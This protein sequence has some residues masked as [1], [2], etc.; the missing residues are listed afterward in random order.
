VRWGVLGTGSI[1]A[2]FVVDLL[3][4]G[5]PGNQVVAVGSRSA[6][7]AARFGQRFGIAREHVGADSLVGDE[8][9]DVVYV[10]TPNPFHFAHALGA[11]RAGK[12]VLVEK[13]FVL[14]AA[15]ARRLVEE[16]RDNGVLLVEAMWTRF[17]PTMQLVRQVIDGGEIG[18]VRTLAAQLGQHAPYE[19]ESRLWSRRLG[20]GALLDMGPYLLALASMVLGPA[21]S[22][23][24]TSSRAPTGVD[25][26]TSIVLRH[27]GGRHSLLHTSLVGHDDNR[28]VI[29]GSAGRLEIPAPFHQQQPVDIVTAD[30]AVR[31]VDV[32]PVGHGL[33]F[34]AQEVA[35]CWRAGVLESPLMPLQDTVSI[36][37]TLDQIRCQ[38]GLPAAGDDE[39][40]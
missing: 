5:G 32:P 37:E 36:L 17:L 31:Q 33:H 20:G 19:P 11:I 12:A 28:A 40:G 8:D 9:V 22:V 15:Q 10:A 30:G 24:A 29:I 2:L 34:E 13:P 6:A 23:L 27:A 16:A 7:A 39:E 4:H 18:E 26:Q 1:A 3:A 38:A 14:D 35:R 25:E 21:E